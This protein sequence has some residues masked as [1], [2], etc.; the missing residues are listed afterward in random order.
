MGPRYR[1]SQDILKGL[2]AAEQ[3]DPSGLSG[4]ILLMHVGTDPSRT[5][6]LY[7]RLGELLVELRARGY[8]FGRFH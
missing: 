1:S 6:K 3:R 5:D 7:N 4:C 8:S 2:L